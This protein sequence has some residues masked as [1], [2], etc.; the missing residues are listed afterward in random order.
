MGKVGNNKSMTL[1][2]YLQIYRYKKENIQRR[3]EHLIEQMHLK[4]WA[5][6]NLHTGNIIVS[7][8]PT[9]KITGMWVIDFGRAF[10]IKTMTERQAFLKLKTDPVL[11]MFSTQS[12][13]R[14]TSGQVPIRVGKQN[15]PRRADV[16]MMNIHFNKRI[17]PVQE[18]KWRNIRRFALSETKKY[19]KPTPKRLSATIRSARSAPRTTRSTTRP[20]TV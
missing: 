11:K 2:R 15:L 20:R 9:G 4:G 13:F 1:T 3:V 6:G 17:E 18:Q 14:P 16:H 8:S 5:H 10:K 12:A 19:L 7:V